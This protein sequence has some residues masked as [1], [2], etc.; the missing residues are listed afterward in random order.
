M[1]FR[2]QDPAAPSEIMEVTSNTDVTLT[3][4]LT[5]AG[6]PTYT[7][8][9][10][11][12][13]P[14]AVGLD[15]VLTIQ[16]AQGSG[17]FPTSCTA[18]AATASGATSIPV[19]GFTPF[20]DTTGA[21]SY[22]IGTLVIDET[23]PAALCQTT[24]TVVRGVDGTTPVA[25]ATGFTVEGVLSATPLTDLLQMAGFYLPCLT[26]N[27]VGQ[28]APLSSQ[29]LNG[30]QV[31]ARLYGPA[32]DVSKVQLNVATTSTGSIDVGVYQGHGIGEG[33]GQCAPGKLMVH[34]G[35]ISVPA[36]GLATIS[37]PST[38]RVRPGDWFSIACTDNTASFTSMTTTAAYPL[39]F[40]TGQLWGLSA[41][42]LPA[43]PPLQPY[44]Q[45]QNTYQGTPWAVLI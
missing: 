18:S 33:D 6:A 35:N 22:A 7:A 27:P 5:A 25:H 3:S 2:I 40:G 16:P 45:I 31:L 42:N 12:A 14:G 43:S 32:A 37:L 30:R 10:V 11:T 28:L 29:S 26:T 15:D 1:S 4:A 8:L 17:L 34:T 9:P 36:A 13:T 23:N 19:T 20:P 39:Q 41:P 44:A 21:N 24:W 38:V